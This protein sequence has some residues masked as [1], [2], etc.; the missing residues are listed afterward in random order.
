MVLLHE[1]GRNGFAW[2][3]RHGIVGGQPESILPSWDEAAQLSET[4]STAEIFGRSYF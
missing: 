4:N 2:K 3:Q 1:L